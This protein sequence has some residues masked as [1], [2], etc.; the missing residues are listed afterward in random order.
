[1]NK[2]PIECF[3]YRIANLLESLPDVVGSRPEYG[4][5]G[6]MWIASLIAP[7]TKVQVKSSYRVGLNTYG[8]IVAPKGDA[9]SPALAFTVGPI[10]KRIEEELSTYN[11]AFANWSKKL[12]NLKRD[13]SKKGNEAVLDH[14]MLEPKPPWWGVITIGTS[15]GIR[16]TAKM[17]AQWEHPPFIGQFSEEL[18]GW[19]KS[20]GKYA[21]NGNDAGEMGF[22]LQAYDGDMT[23]KAN[24]GEKDS[25][26]R[27]RLGLLGTIQPNVFRNAFDGKIENGLLDRFIIVSGNGE[28]QDVDDPY[29]LWPEGVVEDY[30]NYIMNLYD[31]D[32][33][34]VLSLPDSCLDKGR[35]MNAWLKKTD[36]AFGAEA[37]SKWWVH[38]HK[39]IGILTVL[40]GK[41]RITPEIVDK[42]IELTKYL[43]IS[44][45]H[46]FR[47][48][49]MSDVDELEG[50]VIDLLRIE[51]LSK[52]GISRVIDS[53]KRPSLQLCIDDMLNTGLIEE[54]T[55]KAKNGRAVIKYQLV[56]GIS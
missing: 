27:F 50:K 14:E 54:C 23:I 32:I 56:R 2:F 51:P 8:A 16:D 7:R 42:A 1:M 38:Y 20:M 12:D 46:S 39:I 11:K 30:D 47:R 29:C 55:Q 53:K 18:D 9:K 25:T 45:C 5:L 3:P 48:M 49:A 6:A 35:E 52:S 26:P 34:E 22:Y 44:W 17:N 43:V 33:P 37:S 4:A 41:T 31:S 40:W 19:V 24:K 15:E 21:K 13:R 36:K 10:M 28:D